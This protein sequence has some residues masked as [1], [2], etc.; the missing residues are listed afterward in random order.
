MIYTFWL[1]L[2]VFLLGVPSPTNAA[3]ILQVQSSTLLQIG[4]HNRTYTVQLACSSVDSS[5]EQSARNLLRA[6]LPRRKKVNLR[7][8]G[9][10]EGILLARVTPLGSEKDLSKRLVEAGLAKSSCDYA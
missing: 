10:E 1:F 2:L 7:P 6:E 9:S 4:D 3:E 8:E 5:D